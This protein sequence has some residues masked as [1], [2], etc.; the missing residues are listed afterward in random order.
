MPSVK[1]DASSNTADKV[2]IH[3][4]GGNSMAGFCSKK[5]HTGSTPIGGGI[6]AIENEQV[7]WS[8][9]MIIKQSLYLLYRGPVFAEQPEPF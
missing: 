5:R 3:R 7:V 4:L 6:P 2:T 1:L 9:P 8:G